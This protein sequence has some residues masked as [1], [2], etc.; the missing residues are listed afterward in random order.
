MLTDF[1]SELANRLG[2]KSTTQV[3]S[4]GEPGEEGGEEGGEEEGVGKE[5]RP[6]K[7]KSSKKKSSSSSSVKKKK[8]KKKNKSSSRSRTSSKLSHGSKRSGQSYTVH[9]THTIVY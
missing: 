4:D 3:A 9:C 7:K 5:R 6:S 2:V 8:K 1:Q